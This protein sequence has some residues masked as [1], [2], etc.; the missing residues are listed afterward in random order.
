MKRHR[1]LK[2]QLFI[3]C[4][5]Q[6]FRFILQTT[7]DNR[8]FFLGPVKQRT[9]NFKLINDPAKD[10]RIKDYYSEHTNSCRRL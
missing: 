9:V 2:L 4:S 6:N 5:I 1:I 7:Y 8:N 10:S 3:I